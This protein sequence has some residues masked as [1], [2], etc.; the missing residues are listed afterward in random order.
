M[1]FMCAH[2][3]DLFVCQSRAHISYECAKNDMAYDIEN[4]QNDDSNEQIKYVN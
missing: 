2:Y 4:P 1:Q 3:G